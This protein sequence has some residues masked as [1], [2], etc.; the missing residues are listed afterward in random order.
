MGVGK[1]NGVGEKE[2]GVD[3]KNGV[4]EKNNGG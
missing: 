4:L 3:K 2:W 1:N